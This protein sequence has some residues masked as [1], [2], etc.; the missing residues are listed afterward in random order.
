M[1]EL[2]IDVWRFGG[3]VELVAG[4]E[5]VAGISVLGLVY[6]SVSAGEGLVYG[7]GLWPWVLD[8]VS[9]YGFSVGMGCGFDCGGIWFEI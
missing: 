3:G 4:V 9:S 8:R 2:G 7:F 6:G 1:V 5:S